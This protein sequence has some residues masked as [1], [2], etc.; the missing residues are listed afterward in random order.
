MSKKD[1]ETGANISDNRRDTSFGYNSREEYTAAM[2]A[3]VKNG[4]ENRS[5]RRALKA[6][7]RKRRKTRAKR[8]S[9]G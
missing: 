1:L 8:V 6:V 9:T 3:M 4:T 7:E 5:L 2:E